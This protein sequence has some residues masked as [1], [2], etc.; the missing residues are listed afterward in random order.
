M[1]DPSAMVMGCKEIQA[2]VG[3][4]DVP[5]LEAVR[6]LGMAARLALHTR[7]LPLVSH[8]TPR[9]VASHF[10]NM[11]KLAAERAVRL[12]AEVELVRLQQTGST[13]RGERR[14]APYHDELHDGPDAFAAFERKF[15]EAEEPKVELAGRLA[16]SPRS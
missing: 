14:T 11:P 12:L 1:R 8:E 6:E 9:P 13:I 3:S 15:N 7:G 4:N 5:E 16:E 10:L 2:T